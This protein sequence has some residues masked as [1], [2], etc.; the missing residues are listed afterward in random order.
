MET[1]MEN[2]VL[3]HSTVPTSVIP[4]DMQVVYFRRKQVATTES[5]RAVIVPRLNVPASEV[6]S[7][8]QVLLIEALQDVI[9]SAA[10]DI[11]RSYC[12]SNPSVTEIEASRFT[13]ASV[14]ARMAEN[15]TS[16]RLNGEQIATWYDTSTTALEAA[17]RYKGDEKKCNLLR[18]KYMSLASNNPSILPDLA[19]KMLA[20]MSPDDGDSMVARALAKKLERLQSTSVDVSEL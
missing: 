14:V 19:T 13:F 10:A 16:Q 15:Q 20:Y 6:D 4:S 8:W 1:K 5:Y 7:A 2:K 18:E 12:D 17:T 9:N 3:I 11:L